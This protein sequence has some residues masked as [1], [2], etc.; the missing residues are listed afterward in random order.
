MTIPNWT[1]RIPVQED[2]PRL[3]DL[4]CRSDEH[5]W[6]ASQLQSVVTQQP[7]WMLESDSALLG[8]VVFQRV[9]DEAELH[10]LVVA[11]LWQHRGLGRILLGTSLD[12]LAKEGCRSC[13][14]EVRETNLPAQKLYANL[15]FTQVGRRSNYYASTQG[16]FED[17][18]ILCRQLG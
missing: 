18:L 6:K 4:A 14:L 9:L 13:F 12:I 8:F 17:A 1:L 2:I 16:Q 11:R 7:C 10:Y 3:A 15:A 5:P